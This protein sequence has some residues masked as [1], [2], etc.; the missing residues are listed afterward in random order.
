[1]RISRLRL[2]APLAMLACGV[3]AA[4]AL[5]G[6]TVAIDGD[7]LVYAGDAGDPINV[8]VS[9]SGRMLRLDENGSRIAVAPGSACTVS[10][11]GYRADCE[12]DG[13]ARIRVTAG[14]S[15]SDV[16]IRAALPAELIGGPGDDVLIGG[17][18]DDVIDG[19]P[20]RDVI[21]GG[22]GA[23]VLRGGDDEDLVTYVDQIAA[24]G[25]LRPR[26][27]GVTV[28]IG[29]DGASGARDEG[30]TIA[31]DVEQIEGGAGADRFE[32][33][34]GLAQSV[35]CGGGRDTVILDERDDPSIDCERG[36]VGPRAGARMSIPTLIYPFPGREDNDRSTIR[37]KPTLPLQRGAI[38]VRVRC[39]TAIGL[40]ANDGPGCAGTLRMTRAGGFA[41]A[42]KRVSLARNRTMTWRV[43]LT[44]SRSLARRAGGLAVTVSA[45]PTRGEGVRRDLAFTV[46]G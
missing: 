38:V 46:K 31:R 13:I 26:R 29:A 25:D 20:G 35:A 6:G 32:L 15:G 42:T 40:L 24:N 1:M 16:R 19:G 43:P 3:T 37:V 14:V 44:S 9:E 4:P 28:R 21:G 12:A 7:T 17:P 36:Q 33:R 18:G 39:Q 2:A 5:A 10:A 41:M 11:D 23:D 8:I 45:L 27:E 30:D 34:D 22:G